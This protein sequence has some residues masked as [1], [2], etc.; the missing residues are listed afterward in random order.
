MRLPLR[1][2]G[3]SERKQSTHPNMSSMYKLTDPEPTPP[4]HHLHQILAYQASISPAL[5]QPGSDPRQPE[6]ASMSQSPQEV[7]RLANLNIVYPA[8]LCFS[9]RHPY[10]G[11]GLCLLVPSASQ[12]PLVLPHVAQND[13]QCLPFPGMCE[14]KLTSS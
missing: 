3:N 11:C 5:N 1:N 8:L 13:M 2:P 7:F 9:H 6:K 12:L 10:K 4:N 14:Y